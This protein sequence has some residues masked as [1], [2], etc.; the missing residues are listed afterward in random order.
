MQHVGKGTTKLAVQ[1]WFDITHPTASEANANDVRELTGKVTYF[2]TPKADENDSDEILHSRGQ[3]PLGRVLV[4]R[5]NGI[6]GGNA[7]A[8]LQ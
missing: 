8:L 3:V 4:Y 1:L 2:I 5:S 7:R 6:A